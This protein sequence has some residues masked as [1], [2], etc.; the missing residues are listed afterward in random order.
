MS[1]GFLQNVPSNATAAAL[2][3]TSRVNKSIE[4]TTQSPGG[5]NVTTER[6][7]GS[8]PLSRFDVCGD[9][10]CKSWQTAYAEGNFLKRLDPAWC[11]A[12]YYE[13]FGNRSDL[14]LVATFDMVINEST[15]LA[16]NPLFFAGYVGVSEQ[17][18]EFWGCELG[19][20]NNIPCRNPQLWTSHPEVTDG[21]NVLGYQIDY[22]LL[23]EQSLQ[24]L[25]A[26][27]SSLPIMI[28]KILEALQN[29]ADKFLKLSASRIFANFFACSL[30]QF[31]AI[32]QLI[33]RK[34]RWQ[35]WGMQLC[36]FSHLRTCTQRH[37][38]YS[39]RLTLLIA[40]SGAIQSLAVGATLQGDGSAEQASDIGSSPCY[41]EF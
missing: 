7:I 27:R 16:S 38:V 2:T 8:L 26:V 37:V 10:D 24:N 28:G 25:C 9:D 1:P 32:R 31:K 21:W 34:L 14:I 15:L 19:N 39:T 30:L 18:S 23:A 35:P 17:V 33:R 20:T 13:S 3:I 40:R 4:L 5:R 22:C 11:M 29:Q 6:R 41:R 12:E 36:P